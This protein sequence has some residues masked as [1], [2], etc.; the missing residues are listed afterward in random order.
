MAI[1]QLS[2]TLEFVKNWKIEEM[3][4][5]VFQNFRIF[6]NGTYMKDHFPMIM[7]T[8]FQVNILEKWLSFA[9]L[10]VKKD[11]FHV[12]PGDA[13]II[14]IFKFCPIW[15]VQKEF[16]AHFFVFATKNRAKT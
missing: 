11:N 8:T 16:W 4:S 6:K 14:L 9:I 12:I 1:K 15:V 7:Y 3:K 13:G 5:I 10:N 2:Q